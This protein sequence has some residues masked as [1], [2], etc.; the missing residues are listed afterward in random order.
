M[1]LTHGK[2]H[3]REYQ[4]WWRIT[5]HCR[6]KNSPAFSRFGAKGISV[7]D[8]W[9]TFDGFYYDMGEMPEDCNTI[10]RVDEKLDYFGANCRWA[11]VGVGR[12][13]SNKKKASKSN[14]GRFKDPYVLGITVE[15]DLIEYIKR[16]AI[17]KSAEK[18]KL[19]EP[20]DLIREALTKAF[21][22]LCQT[23]IFGDPVKRK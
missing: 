14:S 7:C 17:Q 3:S 21:P 16:V 1:T 8:A 5:Q 18:G 2:T 9:K 22:I 19:V 4:V 15:K 11:Y 13:R 23:D 20:N 10:V 12:P 6:N